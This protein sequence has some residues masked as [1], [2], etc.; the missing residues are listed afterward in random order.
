MG[1]REGGRSNARLFSSC[2]E[3]S[4]GS[5]SVGPVSLS[6]GHELL[7]GALSETLS[8]SSLSCSF[9][10]G[11]NAT[12]SASSDDCLAPTTFTLTSIFPFS[13]PEAT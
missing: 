6:E 10:P 3:R 2:G 8:A 1:K 9:A 5:G 11:C 4:S 7:S 13:F 12:T